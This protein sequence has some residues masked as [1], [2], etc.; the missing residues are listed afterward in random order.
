MIFLC[1]DIVIVFWSENRVL[2]SR[3]IEYNLVLMSVKLTLTVLTLDTK[4]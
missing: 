1:N 3:F 2:T 4:V